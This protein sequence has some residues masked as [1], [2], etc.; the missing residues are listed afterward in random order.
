M[1]LVIGISGVTNGGKTSITNELKK[2]WKK[3]FV[4]HTVHQDDYYKDEADI[5]VDPQNGLLQWDVPEAFHMVQMKAAIKESILKLEQSPSQ[6]ILIVEGILLFCDSDLNKM[7]DRRYF[8]TLP[9]DEAKLRRGNRVY[10]PPDVPGLFEKHVWPMYLHYKR[11][12]E[13]Y[14][15]NV[16]ILDGTNDFKTVVDSVQSDVVQFL[17]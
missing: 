14:V 7:F 4:L 11:Q 10:E 8:L 2:R 3:Q 17:Q 13:K 6:T 9:L 1:V 15:E 5:A 12:M 16:V